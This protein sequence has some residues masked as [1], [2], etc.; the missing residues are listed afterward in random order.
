MVIKPKGNR[1]PVIVIFMLFGVI[2]TYTVM[3]VKIVLNVM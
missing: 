2:F 1:R 3:R